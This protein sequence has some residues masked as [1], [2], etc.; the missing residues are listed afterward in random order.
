MRRVK[1]N[2]EDGIVWSE[3][4]GWQIA[5]AALGHLSSDYPARARMFKAAV[6]PS[7]TT[8][9]AVNQLKQ[10]GKEAYYCSLLCSAAL[11]T[12]NNIDIV[13]YAKK[14]PLPYIFA[15]TNFEDI[16]LFWRETVI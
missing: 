8:Q 2:R 15:Q 11:V 9:E 10:K 16:P 4:I 13:A 3:A 7:K 5:I 6:T 12:G 1:N 14:A